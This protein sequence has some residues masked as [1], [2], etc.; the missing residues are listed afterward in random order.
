M[1]HGTLNAERGTERSGLERVLLPFTCP[2]YA[3]LKH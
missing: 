2:F 3:F 1:Q